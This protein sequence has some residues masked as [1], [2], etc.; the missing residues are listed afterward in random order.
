MSRAITVQGMNIGN[1]SLKKLKNGRGLARFDVMLGK[2]DDLEK[3]MV[4]LRQEEGVLSV[5]RQ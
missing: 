3:V 5:S 1:V 4:Q 2:L